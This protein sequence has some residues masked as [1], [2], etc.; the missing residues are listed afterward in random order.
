MILNLTP[1]GHPI[2]GVHVNGEE[3]WSVFE[4]INRVCEKPKTMKGGKLAENSYASN[5]FGTLTGDGSNIKDSDEIQFTLERFKD[6]MG[7]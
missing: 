7:P 3:R 6:A 1:A 5:V 4:F 2:R